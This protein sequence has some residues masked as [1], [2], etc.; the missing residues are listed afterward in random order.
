MRKR[1]FKTVY[2]SLFFF[3]LNQGL[4]AQNKEICIEVF[5][6]DTAV[7]KGAVIKVLTSKGKETSYETNDLGKLHLNL[8]CGMSYYI[9]CDYPNYH[10]AKLK[11]M[12]P[13]EELTGDS[14]KF[15]MKSN[16]IIH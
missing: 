10:K 6:N 2:L 7:A 9:T 5:D 11:L 4:I 16:I 8:E 12:K 1:I 15:F 14:I 3:L 13:C